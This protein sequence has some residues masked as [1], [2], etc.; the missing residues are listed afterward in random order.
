MTDAT[1]DFNRANSSGLGANWSFLSQTL[2]VVSNHAE[3]GV[4][5]DHCV[6]YWNADSFDNDQYSEVDILN[7]AQYIGACVRLQTGSFSGYIAFGDP[8]GCSIYRVDG[9]SF[10]SLNNTP[11]ETFADGDLLRLTIAGS[12]LTL[13]RNGTT[14]LTTSDSNYT[15]GQPGFE[16]F[17]NGGNPQ[18]DSWLGGPIAGGGGAAVPVFREHLR[19]LKAA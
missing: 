18:V 16:I 7:S 2:D 17:D 4:G 9:G 15:S 12:N 3:A 13:T 14:V 11:S 6:G 5:A 1:D 8:G 19:R 10:T